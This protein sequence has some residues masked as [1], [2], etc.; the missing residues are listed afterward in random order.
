MNPRHLLYAAILAAL[1]L[2]TGCGAKTASTS[3]VPPD[4]LTEARFYGGTLGNEGVFVGK[5]I[6]EKDGHK[7]ALAIAGDPEIHP[8]LPGDAR[9]MK[10]L[11]AMPHGIPVSV[12]GKLFPDLGVIV[13]SGVTAKQ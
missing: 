11:K 8:L 2:V 4:A 9:V 6:R 12:D 7:F 5:L 10:Q 13:V 3:A 1:T